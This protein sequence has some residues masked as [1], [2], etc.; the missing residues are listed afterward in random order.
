[1][2]FSSRSASELTGIP[3]QT[4]SYWLQK[5]LLNVEGGGQGRAW[6]LSAADCM[7]ALTIR[8]LR[9]DGAA[10]QTIR[11]AVRQLEAWGNDDW[12]EDWLFVDAK[13]NVG[14]FD[15]DAEQMYSLKNG[16]AY[17]VDVAGLKEQMRREA[18][19]R[20]MEELIPA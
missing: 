19:A 11:E 20:D 16:Q 12:Q 4:L 18:R 13:G 5:G 8:E 15:Q 1:M 17:L 14:W 2:S 7:R 6:Q 10:L 9:N 3:Q